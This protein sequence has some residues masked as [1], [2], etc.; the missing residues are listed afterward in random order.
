MHLLTWPGCRFDSEGEF[1]Q[2]TTTA[3]LLEKVRQRIRHLAK[4][5]GKSSSLPIYD[6]QIRNPLKNPPVISIGLIQTVRPT[7]EDLQNYG[8]ELNGHGFRAIQRAHLASLLRLAWEHAKLR[9][10]YDKNPQLD[11]VVLPEIAVHRQ[12]VDLVERFID[13]TQAIVFCGL[14]FYKH[15]RLNE[16]VNSGLWI[17]PE[18][19]NTGRS[20]RYLLQGKEHMM[21]S[22][23][24]LKI[25]SHRPHQYILRMDIGDGRKPV[26]ISGAI[27][28]DATDLKLASDLRDLTDML[29]IPANNKDVP[30]FDTMATALS[31]HMFQ[32]VVIVNSGE[33]GGTVVQ[34]P[35]KERH[36]RTLVHDHGGMQAA[37]S[38]VEIDL[39]DYQRMREK[40]P[41]ELKS[42]PAGFARH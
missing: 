34:A 15:E 6:V 22:E 36:E 27:C 7:H 13:A 35:Y 30:T 31:W 38:I 10:T 4:M 28:F 33:F 3:K 21:K 39:S 26:A 12:D 32:H 8:P 29:I 20:F 42:P 24:K 40:P 37:I 9:K 5:Y 23:V 11:V 17:L 25:R 16:L 19:R 41:H 14:S 1:S 18:R 2:V